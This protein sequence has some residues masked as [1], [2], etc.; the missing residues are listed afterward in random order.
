[1]FDRPALQ[2]Q[3]R[4]ENISELAQ[5]GK[6]DNIKHQIITGLTSDL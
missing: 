3:E 5:S 4:W 1:M 2:I 6:I